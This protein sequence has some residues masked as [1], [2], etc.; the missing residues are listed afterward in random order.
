MKDDLVY[1]GH[2]VD[3]ARR[4]LRLVDG[5]TRESF[6][7]NDALTLAVTHL[8]QTIGEAAR[9]VGVQSK[10]S[11]DPMARDCGHASPGGA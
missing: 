1:V 8:L 9:R 5:V 10:I 11:G 6:E 7:T 2:M 3:S 4:A